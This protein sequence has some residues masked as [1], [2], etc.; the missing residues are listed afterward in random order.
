ML[1]EYPTS[2][3]LRFRLVAV[4]SPLP[5]V[6]VF[7]EPPLVDEGNFAER[8]AP[9]VGLL[10]PL[11][12][13]TWSDRPGTVAFHRVKWFLVVDFGDGYGKEEVDG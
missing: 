2:K 4:A 8:V 12:H 10:A 9:L 11:D 13:P 6:V 5:P 7:V 1:Y 3:R